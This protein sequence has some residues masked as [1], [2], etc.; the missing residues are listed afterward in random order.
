MA[1]IK[2]QQNLKHILMDYYRLPTQEVIQVLET[3]PQGL[4]SDQVTQRRARSGL[5]EL[6]ETQ[7]PSLLY[8]FIQQFKSPLIYVLLIAALIIFFVGPDKYDAFIISG[9]LLFNAFIGTLQEGR[10]QTILK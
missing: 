9:I 3:S 8:I 7:P 6:P 10:T 2:T 4:T 5:N 1:T